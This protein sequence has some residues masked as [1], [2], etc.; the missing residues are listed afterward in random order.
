MPKLIFAV[1][2]WRHVR[3]ICQLVFLAVFLLLFRGTELGRDAT[4]PYANLAFRLDPLIAA[5]AMLAAKTFIATLAL[6]LILVVL[7]AAFGRFFDKQILGLLPEGAFDLL[8]GHDLPVD[9]D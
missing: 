4:L 7:T 3:R 5:S 9:A 2:R 8:T 6:S 1:V